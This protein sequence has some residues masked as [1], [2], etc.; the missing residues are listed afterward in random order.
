MDAQSFDDLY[1]HAADSGQSSEQPVSVE[2]ISPD[3]TEAG[4]Q[5]NAGIKSHGSLDSAKQ[6]LR[7]LFKGKYG[8][9]K[10]TYPLFADSSV[11]E[12]DSLLLVN[13]GN[14][15][16]AGS[17]ATE[18]NNITYSRSAWLRASQS[19]M[20]NLGAHDT[21]VHLYLNGLYWG[22]YNVVER[23]DSS[24][25]ASYL[26]GEKE[27]WFVADQG[28]PLGNNERTDRLSDLFTLL[29]LSR[30]VGGNTE[31]LTQ[32]YNEVAASLDRAQFS[33]YLIL[34]WYTGVEPG[35][36]DDW[37][38]GIR[39]Q[40]AMGRRGKIII[41]ENSEIFR[42]DGL[43]MAFGE[44]DSYSTSTTKALFDT[45]MQDP[46]FKM[47]LADRMYGHLFNDG[48][49][50]DTNAQSRWQQL[51]ADIDQAILAELARWGDANGETSPTQEEWL[52]AGDEVLA[53]MEGNADR[54]IAQA[55]EAGYYPQ[56]DPPTLSLDGGLVEAGFTVTMALPPSCQDC[57]IY[58]TT[59]RSDPRLPVTGEVMPDAMAYSTP[60][61]L[62][63][64]TQ[65]KARV[66]NPAVTDTTQ[67]WSALQEATF[68][69]MQQDYKLRITEVMYNP[70]SGDDYEFIELKNVGNNAVNL[71]NISIDEG[72]RF[73]FPPN[74]PLLAPDEFA[75]LV[76]NPEAFA[77]RYPE[78]A[79]SGA[80]EGHLSNKGEKI[81]LRDAEG[82]TLLEFTYNDE[83]GWPV[84]ADGRGDSLTLVNA[85]GDPN[86]P[87]NWR[88]SD[89]LNGSPGADE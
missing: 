47:Q 68:N 59:N 42:S 13:D 2:L 83:N 75:V 41:G 62:T 10:L 6:S 1:I 51:Y 49:L 44:T 61:M 63:S 14:D 43:E 71:A 57:T 77:E 69:V 86:N 4:F 19:A 87:Q 88:V 39:R 27:D 11:T 28:G 7:L 55:R 46:D 66:F 78:V 26:G 52:Q 17:T 33:D 67:R 35:A 23:P 29:N 60:V 58:Y 38:V 18:Q 79:I 64:S 9:T 34:N 20:S 25:M 30:R 8:A 73:S 53:Q 36:E 80:Y 40:D 74:T 50:T 32:I 24:F 22:L 85:S 5:I 3:G 45:L 12:F 72:I 89:Q 76:S 81:V 84:S 54:L 82:Q 56:F 48:A 37:Y 65:L 21:Y 31:Q 70:M 16:F 15:S